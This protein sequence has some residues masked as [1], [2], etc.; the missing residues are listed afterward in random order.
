ML[1]RA[2]MEGRPARA[3]GVVMPVGIQYALTGGAFVFA[4]WAL[5]IHAG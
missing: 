1:I 4:I 2:M 5:F 3:R